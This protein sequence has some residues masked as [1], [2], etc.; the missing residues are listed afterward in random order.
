[1][2][3]IYIDT[4]DRIISYGNPAG[5]IKENKAI[6]DPIFQTDELEQFL[7]KQNYDTEWRDGVYDRLILG[8]QS[9]FDPEA[10]ALKSCRI[11]Q[12]S[13]DT[14]VEMRFISYDKMVQR[15]GEPDPT[16]YEQVYDGQVES[17]DL[18]ALYDKFSIPQPGFEGHPMALSD[19]VE[20]YDESGSTFHY[21]DRTGF[22]EIAFDP[23]QQHQTMTM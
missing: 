21:C 7:R 19:V 1:M 10:P 14:P 8:Q 6:A 17:N 20:L 9:G 22:R 15:F 16:R 18:E 23:P 2:Q 11:W 13:S 5:Y 12:L 4:H 3:K